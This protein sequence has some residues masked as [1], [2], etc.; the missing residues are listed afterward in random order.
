VSAFDDQFHVLERSRWQH[1]LRD[2]RLIRWLL[3][4][5]VIYVVVGGRIRR[6]YVRCRRDGEIFWLD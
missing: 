2:L 5:F 6:K 3:R 1:F 4:F